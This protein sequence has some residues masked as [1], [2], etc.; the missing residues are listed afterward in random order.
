[1]RRGPPPQAWGGGPRW[2]GSGGGSLDER[3]G[4]ENV[5]LGLGLSEQRQAVAAK[6]IFLAGQP[7]G[8][9]DCVIGGAHD[10]LGDK[11]AAILDRF[12]NNKDSFNCSGLQTLLVREAF[13]E[14]MQDANVS[15]IT[16]EAARVY[17]KEFFK[18][19]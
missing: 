17:A 15:T 4:H 2:C 1:M 19:T 18:E 5:G 16:P 14:Y 11:A 7:Y 8:V 9:D 6:A 12:I 13:P 10:V 3:R